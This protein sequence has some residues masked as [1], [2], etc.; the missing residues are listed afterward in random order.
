MLGS[1]FPA[2]GVSF[3]RSTE[4][5][6]GQGTL[7]GNQGNHEMAGYIAIDDKSKLRMASEMPSDYEPYDEVELCGNRLIKLERWFEVEGAFPIFVGRG[8]IGPGLW[9]RGLFGHRN[10]WQEVVRDNEILIPEVPGFGRVSFAASAGG[11]LKLDIGSTCVLACAATS[12]KRT[13]RLTVSHLNFH[14]MRLI[15]EG[16]S[17]GVLIGGTRALGN[18]LRNTGPAFRG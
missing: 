17:N 6:S 8:Y 2:P 18:T 4:Q 1:A 7:G 14:P 16:G 5:L 12:A 15:I 9:L 10:D 13:P 3:A 11:T